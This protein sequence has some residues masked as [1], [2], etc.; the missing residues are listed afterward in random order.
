MHL[1]GSF[2]GSSRDSY[3][4]KAFVDD[5][6]EPCCCWMVDGGYLMEKELLLSES[7]TWQRNV[8]ITMAQLVHLHS[9]VVRSFSP[10]HDSEYSQAQTQHLHYHLR[11]IITWQS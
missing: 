11:S 1:E 7:S 3:Q 10:P 6:V 2:H 4:Y 8:D 9:K 5:Y